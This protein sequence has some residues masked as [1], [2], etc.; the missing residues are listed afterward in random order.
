MK[1]RIPSFLALALGLA[2]ALPASASKRTQRENPP[3]TSSKAQSK[4][5]SKKK[6]RRRANMTVRHV[7]SAGTAKARKRGSLG[8]SPSASA[9]RGHGVRL[10][11]SDRM[12][13]L[14]NFY[15]SARKDLILDSSRNQR[16]NDSAI[17][18]RQEAT[19][20]ESAK[21]ET[22]N[23]SPFDFMEES[24]REPTKKKLEKK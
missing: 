11:S 13:S 24:E 22:F 4:S 14:T 10:R 12:K 16:K 8:L 2:V 1:A 19:R 21:K 3:K 20:A 23:P 6:K 7:S 15:D 5:Q 17:R 9:E 18:H